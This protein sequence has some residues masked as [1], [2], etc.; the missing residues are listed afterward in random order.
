[1]KRLA[2]LKATAGSWFAAAWAKNTII[3]GFLAIVIWGSIIAM[4]FMERTIPEVLA[5]AGGAVIAF[6]YR[7]K[8]EQDKGE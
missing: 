6:F 8:T 3:T 4:A 5:V 7:F 2:K 1:M